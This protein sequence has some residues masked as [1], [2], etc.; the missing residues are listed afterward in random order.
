MKPPA[1]RACLLGGQ[2]HRPLQCTAGLRQHSASRP[3]RAATS[4][5]P[6]RLAYGTRWSAGVSPAGRV[7]RALTRHTADTLLAR[8]WPS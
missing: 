8:W 4:A 5:A 7:L 6:P 3:C 2:A 1:G